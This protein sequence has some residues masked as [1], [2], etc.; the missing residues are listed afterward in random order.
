MRRKRA[1]GVTGKV[2]KRKDHGDIIG[3]IKDSFL[4]LYNLSDGNQQ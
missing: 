2:S 4:L 3:S 1:P